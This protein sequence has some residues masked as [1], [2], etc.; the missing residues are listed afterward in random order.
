M[1]AGWLS[2]ILFKYSEISKTDLFLVRFLR[3]TGG[4]E[5]DA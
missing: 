1:W 4:E 5:E 3:E 2:D